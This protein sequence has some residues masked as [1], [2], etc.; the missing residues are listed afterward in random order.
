MKLSEKYYLK[1]NR[2]ETC[3]TFY[4]V[5]PSILYTSETFILTLKNC[6]KIQATD[7]FLDWIEVHLEKTGFEMK[8][9]E[10]NINVIVLNILNLKER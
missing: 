9:S 2:P 3:P 5:I 6:N 10:E 4:Y 1:D 8:T 7:S